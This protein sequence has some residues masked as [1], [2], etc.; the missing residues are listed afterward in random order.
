[1]AVT[2]DA[3]ARSVVAPQPRTVRF[4]GRDVPVILPKLRDPRI[5]LAIT[6][7]TIITIGMVWLDFRLSIPQVAV[8]LL[9]CGLLDVVRTYRTPSRAGVAGE[10]APDRDQHG[11]DPPRHR[12]AGPRLVVVR[13]LVLLRR[14]RHGRG[15][16]QVLHPL[17]GAARLQ[18]L[19]RGARGGVPGVRR[20][21]HRTA[22]LLVGP[23]R[24]GDARRLPRHRRR[25]RHALPTACNCWAWRPPSTPRSWSASACWRCSAS[26][27]ALSGR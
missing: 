16:H 8:A 11:L 17:P 25:R 24:V 10:R 7:F 5:H 18:P 26:R 15:A 21:P 1:M 19:Q 23:V 9:A 14:R 2:V 13:R 20:R 12:H 22:R 4:R 3:D 27:S 6:T